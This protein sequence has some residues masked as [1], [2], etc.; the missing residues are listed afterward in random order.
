MHKRIVLIIVA[1]II[2][3][4]SVGAERREPHRE[5]I[6][7]EGQGFQKMYTTAYCMGHHTADGSAVFEG[8]CACSEEH[9]GDVAIIYNLEGEFLGYYI[10]ND[11]G[12][13]GVEQGTVI[14]VY[15][16]EYDR[17][18]DWMEVTQGKCWVKWIEGDG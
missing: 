4:I 15:R 17:C 8:G 16:T 13:G 9:I 6:D 5:S 14:D 10:C 12:A 1:A 2:C 3:I 11:T 7:F 18:V